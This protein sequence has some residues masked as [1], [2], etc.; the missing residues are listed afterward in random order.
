MLLLHVFLPI[1]F[2]GMIYLIFRTKS[3]SM[4]R[5][6][7]LFGLEP[8]L[9]VI[10][11]YFVTISTDSATWFFYSLPDGLWVYS[12]TAFMFISWERRFSRESCFWILIGPLL[13]LGGEIGQGYCL[14][15]GTFDVSDLIL[16]LIGTMLPLGV[17]GCIK[18]EDEF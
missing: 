11:G 3:L 16:C 8:F 9:D 15:G 10:R 14:V 17:I 12:L 13:A 18:T 2:G 7:N 1:M 4:F 6:V 5:V